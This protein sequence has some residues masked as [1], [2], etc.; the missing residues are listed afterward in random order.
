MKVILKKNYPQ[1]GFVGD[2]VTVK[3]GYARN[4]LFPRGYAVEA[5][6]SSAKQTR[7]VLSGI[8]AR[9]TKLK[10]EAE[11]MAKRVSSINLE[12]ML[13]MS[14]GGKSFGSV[15]TRD[16]ETSLKE[17]GYVID[18]K[19]IRMGEA[20][21]GPGKYT[22]EVKLHAEVTTAISITIKSENLPEKDDKKQ[23]KT[24]KGRKT[25]SQESEAIAEEA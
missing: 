10:D 25:K 14:E 21:K 4:F 20:I 7:H 18:R 5:T 19:Q 23:K 6:S 22:A 3:A 11:Q 8:L 17:K 15:T 13:K 16:I 24:S 9:R 12:F 1:L 2:T